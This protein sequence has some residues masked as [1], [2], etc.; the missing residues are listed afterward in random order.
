MRTRKGV[1]RPQSSGLKGSSS[2]GHKSKVTR[3]YRWEL[4]SDCERFQVPTLRTPKR[5]DWNQGVGLK[6]ETHPEARLWLSGIPILQL[7]SRMCVIRHMADLHFRVTPNALD[8][9]I[10]VDLSCSCLRKAPRTIL[11]PRS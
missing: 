5:R 10:H 8:W 6:L 11:K 2:P 9:F 7:K 1:R 4:V 3:L